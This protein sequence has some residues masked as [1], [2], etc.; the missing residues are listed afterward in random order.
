MLRKCLSQRKDKILFQVDSDTN[1]LQES[2]LQ[3][4]AN[5]ADKRHRSPGAQRPGASQWLVPASASPMIPNRCWEYRP[6]YLQFMMLNIGIMLTPM[7]LWGLYM[8]SSFLEW[9]MAMAIN[10]NGMMAN[11]NEMMALVSTHHEKPGTC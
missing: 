11:Q 10:P 2:G 1:S 8:M 3:G 6:Q 5:Q 7:I 9:L 4:G